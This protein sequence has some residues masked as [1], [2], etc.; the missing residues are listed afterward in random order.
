MLFIDSDVEFEPEAVFRMLVAQKDIVCTPYRVKLKDP[1]AIKYAVDFENP[2]TVPILAGDLVEVDQGPAGLM[3]IS[4]KVFEKLMEDYPS[5]K[6]KYHGTGTRELDET[7]MY[8]F[9]DTTFDSAKGLW[10]GEDLS[11]CDLAKKAGFKIYAN[12]K[13]ETTHHGTW[14][15]KGKFGDTI[16]KL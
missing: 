15:W 1:E 5:M 2:K 8:N 4:R 11:F 16:K 13:S 10:K 7:Y 12:I 3:L 14:G 6:I 9:W